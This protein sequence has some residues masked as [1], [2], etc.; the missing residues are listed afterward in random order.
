MDRR[1]LEAS[2][3]PLLPSLRGYARALTRNGPYADDLVQETLA[4]AIACIDQFT[5]GT[6]FRSWILRIERNLWFG[7]F[8]RRQ[9]ELPGLDL[10]RHPGSQAPD[11]EWKIHH[12][13]LL[14]ALD[15]LKPEHRDILVTVAVGG[16]SYMEAAARAEVEIGTIKS[17]LFRA[18]EA[19]ASELGGA[20]NSTGE[21]PIGPQP[22]H[23][24]QTT[25]LN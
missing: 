24:W 18:R 4:R 6:N 22:W 10:D 5:P 21:T 1:N 9:R 11:Q 13:D 17:R 19:L 20:A 8:N 16:V 14:D 2:L 15:R 25:V 12:R 7:E 23:A 3:L